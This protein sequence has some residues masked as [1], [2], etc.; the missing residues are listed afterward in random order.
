MLSRTWARAS[1]CAWT[2]RIFPSIH[3][4]RVRGLLIS[5]GYG[6][7]VAATLAALM[8][9]ALRQPV[10]VGDTVFFPPAGPRACPK[11]RP[12]APD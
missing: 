6:F 10:L 3:F 9:E 12:P 2:S 5:L 7:P 4:E 1:S 8:T 11:V